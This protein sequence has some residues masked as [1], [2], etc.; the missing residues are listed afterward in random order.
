MK[1]IITGATGFVGAHFVRY[2][3]ALGHE[4][5]ALGRQ[6]KPPKPLLKFATW[7]KLDLKNESYPDLEADVLIH[8]AGL[9]ADSGS[10]QSFYDTNVIPTLKLYKQFSGKHF[11]YISSSSVYPFID[12][13]LKEEDTIVNKDLSNYGRSKFEAENILLENIHSKIKLTILRPRSIYGPNDRVLLPRILKLHKNKI[14]LLGSMDIE[15][16]MT[17]IDNLIS[18]VDATIKY[19]KDDFEIFNVA[20]NNSYNL[21]DV[22][23]RLIETI[24]G[25]KMKTV[26]LPLNFISYLVRLAA[27]LKIP[28][29]ITPQS[30]D[31]LTKPC[32]LDTSKIEKR[33]GIEFNN[34]F[35]HELE[36]MVAW[37]NKV[38]LPT[39][40]SS[41][42]KLPWLG[43]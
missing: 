6:N 38:G 2:F 10:Y 40:K 43:L 4:V 39:V 3:G 17:H 26:E 27:V 12:Q 24:A 34:N 23:I 20:D 18:A 31:Y 9:T 42:P 11:I 21:K 30:L 37:I 33:L 8:A 35:D 15:I 5:I 32:V 25:K 7:Q 14:L 36:S 41:D 13:P 19:Q 28:L 22:V 1:L 29:S 16:S